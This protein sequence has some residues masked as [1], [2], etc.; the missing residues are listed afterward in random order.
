ML[1]INL[2]LSST[3]SST[4][5]G[6]WYPPSS[7][8]CFRVLHSYWAQE[9]TVS[10]AQPASM[11]PLRALSQEDTLKPIGLRH[12]PA[13]RICQNKVPVRT[14]L[15]ENRMAIFEWNPQQTLTLFK[16]RITCTGRSGWMMY[17]PKLHLSCSPLIPCHTLTGWINHTGS[18]L[19]FME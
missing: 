14:K 11:W 3:H 10:L 4:F 1:R 18:N 19:V 12:L 15:F 13:K 9:N 16:R 6:L 5:P 7:P 2:A 17:S 8:T